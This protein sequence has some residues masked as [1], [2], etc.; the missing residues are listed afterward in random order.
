[1]P[2]GM[3]PDKLEEMATELQYWHK[4][5]K[6]FNIRQ[7]ATLTGEIQHI[8]SVTTWGKYKRLEQCTQSK[9]ILSDDELKAH[10]TQSHAAKRVLAYS[11]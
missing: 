11:K 9:K 4:K 2:V 8:C 3:I 5:R 1:M 10:S 6:S 7:V